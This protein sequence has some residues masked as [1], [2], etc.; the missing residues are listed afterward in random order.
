MAVLPKIMQKHSSYSL[1]PFLTSV[2]PE[3]ILFNHDSVIFISTEVIRA[4]LCAQSGEKILLPFFGTLKKRC[5]AY[6]NVHPLNNSQ[7]RLCLSLL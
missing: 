5:F 2:K 6:I 4:Q 3:G 1:S 7:G